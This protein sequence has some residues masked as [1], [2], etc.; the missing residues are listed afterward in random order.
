KKIS[1]EVTGLILFLTFGPC[2]SFLLSAQCQCQAGWRQYEDRCYLFSNDTKTWLEANA[3]CLDIGKLFFLI[4]LM[5][6]FFQLWLRTQIGA[7]IFWIG[8]ND[9]VV[10]GTWEWSDGTTYI[11][12]L[13]WMQGQ[14]DD[15]GGAEDCVQ[16]VG[17]S[18]GH[19][20]DENCNVKRKY[21]CKH[22]N[23]KC[24]IPAHRPTAHRVSVLKALFSICPAGW[25]SFSGSCYWLFVT[26]SVSNWNDAETQCQRD[27][28]H[29]ASFH[30]QEELSFI[31]AHMPAAAWIGLND[32]SNENH[33]VYT[34]GT[35]ADFVPWA[36]NQPDNW[37]DNED[38][39]QLRGMNHHEPGKLNDDFC[40]STKEFIC[41]K[42]LDGDIGPV[43]PTINSVRLS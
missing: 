20:N 36:P 19:W 13:F 10:E 8:L 11:E 22:V 42:G 5:S 16:V 32:I 3:F 15:W 23:R 12:Y 24:Q 30:S 29:L 25:A 31:T 1:Q 43:Y 18:N 17:Y 37:Q 33:F 35:P 34:D 28:A 21:I 6:F 27:Q 14:P 40:T 38:C 9:Q 4:I 41:K 26:E 39:V 2:I 7:D